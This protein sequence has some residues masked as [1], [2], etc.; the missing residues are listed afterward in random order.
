MWKKIVQYYKD[1]HFKA[2]LECFISWMALCS[3]PF[4][5][6][7]TNRKKRLF[8]DIIFRVFWWLV[9]KYILTCTCEVYFMYTK[10][11]PNNRP[12][13]KPT[14]PFVSLQH[15]LHVLTG[16]LQPKYLFLCLLLCSF[17]THLFAH[18]QTTN[19][20]KKTLFMFSRFQFT[21]FCRGQQRNL[22]RLII[23]Q[24]QSY[25]TAAH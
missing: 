15:P 7:D 19:K 17:Y 16:S 24:V 2:T 20:G 18:C 8:H 4:H 23:M 14:R 13:N 22:Q 21:S 9:T 10:F 25:Y 3:K 1:L 12:P 5:T 11:L 6:F